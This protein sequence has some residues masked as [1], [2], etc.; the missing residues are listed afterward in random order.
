MCT[1][2]DIDLGPESENTRQVRADNRNGAR[3]VGASR[4]E[5]EPGQVGGG[6]DGHGG[7]STADSVAQQGGGVAGRRGLVV[8][9]SCV[10]PDD[11]V[12]V[13][14]A[15]T[16]VFGDFDEPDADLITEG[17]LGEADEPGQLAGQVDGE[18]ARHR[19]GPQALNRTW[20]V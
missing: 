19:S 12:V 7:G 18:P 17:F 2:P 1:V 15:T 8:L 11:G 3:V 14:Q 10:E 4:L 13:D 9:A 16:L 6:V 20:P 5:V